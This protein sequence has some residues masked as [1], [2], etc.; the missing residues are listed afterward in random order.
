MNTQLQ[1]TTQSFYNYNNNVPMQHGKE[2]SQIECPRKPQIPWFENTPEVI[3]FPIGPLKNELPIAGRN[4][5]PLLGEMHVPVDIF[6]AK[7]H[8]QNVCSIGRVSQPSPSHVFFI[9]Q[10]HYGSTNR[11]NLFLFFFPQERFCMK[12]ASGSLRNISSLCEN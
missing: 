4:R 2:S 1:R 12:A 6:S 8:T 9:V 7:T 11:V 5:K 10:T 3:Y